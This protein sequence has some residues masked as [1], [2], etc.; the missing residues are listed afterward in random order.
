MLSTAE[1]YFEAY[2]SVTG[3]WVAAVEAA[4]WRGTWLLGRVLVPVANLSSLPRVRAECQKHALSVFFSFFAI[5]ENEHAL[6]QWDRK[7]VGLTNHLLIQ[8]IKLWSSKQYGRSH[9]EINR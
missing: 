6:L 5:T 8:M 3:I 1:F 9:Q 2:S 4:E 7:N